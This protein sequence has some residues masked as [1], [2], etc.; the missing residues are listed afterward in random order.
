MKK[1][2]KIIGNSLGIIFDR[3]DC[4]IYNLKEGDILDLDDLVIFN[5]FTQMKG[6]IRQD[7]KK[8]KSDKHFTSKTPKRKVSGKVNR[9]NPINDGKDGYGGSRKV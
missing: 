9:T 6:G 3:E 7:D 2:V 4:K 5:K 1:I 8:N